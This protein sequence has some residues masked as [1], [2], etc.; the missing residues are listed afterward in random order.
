[1]IRRAAGERYGAVVDETEDA[2][3]RRRLDSAVRES[4]RRRAERAVARRERAELRRRDMQSRH[5]WRLARLDARSA[6]P[7]RN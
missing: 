5:A 2:E 7:E 6:G 3:W 4:A 1:V